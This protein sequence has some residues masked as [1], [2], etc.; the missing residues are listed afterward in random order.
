MDFEEWLAYKIQLHGTERI[1]S[2]S[3]DLDQRP[4]KKIRI[5]KKGIRTYLIEVIM[6]NNI[7]FFVICFKTCIE[8]GCLLF[9]RSHFEVGQRFRNSRR[10]RQNW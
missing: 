1:V 8:M 6:L 9:R 3:A 5:I 7:Y 2:L 10:R 4:K